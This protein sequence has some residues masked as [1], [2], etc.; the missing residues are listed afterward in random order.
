MLLELDA[1]SMYDTAAENMGKVF[2]STE[3]GGGGTTTPHTVAIA[4]KGIRNILR[5][6]GITT[7]ALEV[8]D[9]LELDMPSID[10]YVFSESNGLVEHC[11]DLGE[12]VNKGQLL[13]RVYDAERTGQAPTE[14]FA[15]I[16]GI[17]TGKHFPGHIKMGDFLAVV[18][19][20]QI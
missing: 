11:V 18:A 20:P 7:G 13:A 9:S 14:Y 12:S 2:I 16:D 17:V 5:H 10:C 8:D 19:C 3:L 15:G 6:A 4:K 1:G